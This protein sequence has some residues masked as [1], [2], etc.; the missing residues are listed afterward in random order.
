MAKELIPMDD[1]GVFANSKYEVMVD[2][3]YVAKIFEK[4]HKNVLRDIKIMM[5]DSGFSE[6]FLRLNFEQSSYLNAQGR[7]QPSYNMTRDGFVALVFGFTG[8]KADAF[9]E[10]YIKRFNDM[11]EHIIMI[12]SLRDQYPRL[13]DALQ[14]VY[15][16]PK[17]YVYSNEADM[18]NKIAFGMTAKQYREKYGIE[19]S[20]PIRPHL[21][22]YSA[23][24]LEHLQRID[25]GLVY[26]MPDFQQRRQK[27]EWCAMK[28][29][30]KHP[31][32]NLIEEMK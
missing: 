15:D 16:N 21:D 7:K 29:K 18:L 2:S 11:E 22:K 3:R 9:K 20:E 31:R 1:Y 6:E 30:E 28:W 5:Q 25:V 24:L 19:K 12:Q 23:E 8:K 27:L 13:T 14:E 26:S 17:F 32:E 4:E 10:S